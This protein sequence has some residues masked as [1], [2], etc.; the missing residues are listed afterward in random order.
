MT[1]FSVQGNLKNPGLLGVRAGDLFFDFYRLQSLSIYG[2]KPDEDRFDNSL[3]LLNSLRKLLKEESAPSYL[4]SRVNSMEK[5][6]RFIENSEKEK[7]EPLQTIY[8]N[9][10]DQ[11]PL[12]GGKI[13]TFSFR[14]KE[15]EYSYLELSSKE[16]AKIS[17]K[18]IF[19]DVKSHF[20]LEF[21]VK[22]NTMSANKL[23]SSGNWEISLSKSKLKFTFDS[24]I[25]KT[26]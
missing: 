16:K 25:E 4:M 12:E 24:G 20:T 2:M 6:L 22:P 9:K 21:W 18:P 1:S 8:F 10:R 5:E 17:I 11:I 3:E 23:I 26:Q 7:E 14:G 19:E 15:Q 13:K